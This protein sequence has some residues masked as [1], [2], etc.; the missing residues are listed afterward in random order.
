[1]LAAMASM[2]GMQLVEQF[3]GTSPFP[4]LVG[5]RLDQ[6]E[7]D[8]VVMSLPFRQDL[9]TMG[10]VVHGGAIA[11]LIDT[12]AT[13]A[14]WATPSPPE[15][16]RGTTVGLNISYLAAANQADLTADARVLR[17]GRSLSFIDVTV[18]DGDGNLIAKG[19]AT[20][21]LG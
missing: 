12:A 5:L 4:A 8:H 10:T 21:K 11:T 2:T 1:M 14:A 9:I 13:C 17:R 16:L 6:I 15:N 18:T 19:T 3:I 20:Y 7:E